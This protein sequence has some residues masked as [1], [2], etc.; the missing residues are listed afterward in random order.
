MCT[1]YQRPNL[2]P[3]VDGLN[4]T[5]TQVLFNQLI[6]Q[7]WEKKLTGL[8]DLGRLSKGLKST[9]AFAHDRIIRYLG[10]SKGGSS[11]MN[12][13]RGVLA[14]TLGGS[15][16]VLSARSGDHFGTVI[17]HTGFAGHP[18]DLLRSCK[19]IFQW[20]ASN[21]TYLEVEQYVLNNALHPMMIPETVSELAISQALVRFRIKQLIQKFGALHGWLDNDTG[22]GLKHQFEPI[23]VSGDV[24][25]EAPQ[26]GQLMLMVL[27]SLQPFGITTIVLD[28]YQLMPLLGV[29]GSQEPILPVHVLASGAFTNLGTVIA[30]ISLLSEGKQIMT[31]HVNT[32]AGKSYDVDIHQGT[33]RRLVIPT[34][35]TAILDIEPD[36]QTDVGFGGFGLGGQLK[37]TG[38]LS[39]VV[40]DARGRPIKLPDNDEDRVALL[41]QWHGVVGG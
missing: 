23:I 1:L 15:T 36:H 32:D 34:G 21:V 6:L 12:N 25:I 3:G 16:S 26:P 33:L 38:G 37:V 7:I 35:V 30:P 24:F 20:T 29:I 10:G 14:I 8:S 22:S 9:T 40:V 17:Q 39:G 31:I 28:Q 41:R 4:L 27:D 2:F 5:P 18:S 19:D 11:E 13:H